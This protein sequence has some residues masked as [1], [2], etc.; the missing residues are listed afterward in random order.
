MVMRQ[1]AEDRG[2][3]R[4]ALA[5]TP[6]AF[7]MVALDTLVVITAL[8]AI[9]HDLGASLSTLEWTVNAFTLSFAA[10]IITAAASGDRFGRRRVFVAGLTL[11]AAASAACAL[12]PTVSILITMR[13]IQGIGAALVTPTGLTILVAAFPPERRG[14][15]VGIWGGLAGLAVAG[16]PLVGGALTQGLSWH[17]IFWVNVPIGV[18][19]A[20]LS[21]LKLPESRGPATALDLPAVGLVTGGAVG[22]VLGLVRGNELGW[23][24]PEVVAS[25]LVG[26]VLL[27][28][29]IV[30]EARAAAPMMPLRLFRS[31][32]FVA[33]NATGFLMTAALIPAAFLMSQYFQFVLGYSPLGTGLRFLPWTATPLVVAPIAGIVSDRIGRRPVM[34]AGMLLQ[35]SGL[36]WCALLATTTT[37]YIQFVPALLIAGVGV[38][39][40][41]AT[42][43]TAALS[44]VPA[45]DMGKASGVNS[46]LQRFGAVFGLAVAT[47][48]FSATGHLGS[49]A[50]FTN[51][52]RPALALAAGFSILGTISA[53]AAGGR[54]GAP[55]GTVFEARV[56]AAVRS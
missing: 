3:G 7:F 48:V 47:A 52:F 29:F 44:A 30:W 5:L 23:G 24:S 20:V 22:L 11:F 26:T 55:S 56:G 16:G 49:A 31:P 40:A 17:W 15:I 19:A 34:V 1:A 9:H 50:S 46:T 54:Q 2:R 4:W 14:A 12:A 53:L 51:G 42:S 33:A 8:P 43:P 18:V 45:S 25:L 21:T 35:G 32:T 27:I 39:M 41:L 38:S 28:G 36:G 10:G 13:A 6:I 37:A